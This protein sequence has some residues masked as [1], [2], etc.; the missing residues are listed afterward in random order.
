MLSLPFPYHRRR[1]Q[2]KIKAA[3][4]NAAIAKIAS[5]HHCFHHGVFAAPVAGDSA[6]VAGGC[7]GT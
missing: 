2:K 4:P 1:Y 6:P 5:T 3:M 7:V